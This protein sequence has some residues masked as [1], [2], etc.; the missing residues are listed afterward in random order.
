MKQSQNSSWSQDMQVLL[1]LLPV[2]NMVKTC[3]LSVI[4]WIREFEKYLAQRRTPSTTGQSSHTF[5]FRWGELKRGA[6]AGGHKGKQACSGQGYHPT[7]HRTN[8]N[9]STPQIQWERRLSRGGW[10]CR[11]QI[12][13]ALPLNTSQKVDHQAKSALMASSR[14]IDLDLRE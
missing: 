7:R 12:I 5:M 2:F 3:M 8:P 10:G 13:Q 6:A 4:A 11:S 14:G 9:L 1:A